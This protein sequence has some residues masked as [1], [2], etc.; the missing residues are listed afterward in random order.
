MKTQIQ[1]YTFVHLLCKWNYTFASDT[2]SRRCLF[3]IKSIHIIQFTIVLNATEI[4]H[5]NENKRGKNK[6]M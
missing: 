4:R 3:S 1:S 2:T 6:V 5:V